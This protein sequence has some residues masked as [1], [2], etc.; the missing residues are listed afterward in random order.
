MHKILLYPF[1]YLTRRVLS[2][3]IAKSAVVYYAPKKKFSI[4]LSLQKSRILLYPKENWDSFFE[5][6]TETY[7]S[8]LNIESGKESAWRALCGFHTTFD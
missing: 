5:W 8:F 2:R 1:L 4:D 3:R 7:M 6:V